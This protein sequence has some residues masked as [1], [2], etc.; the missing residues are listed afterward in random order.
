MARVIRRQKDELF[1]L[2]QRM[3][4]SFHRRITPIYPWVL[5]RVLP[6]EQQLGRIWVPESQNKVIYEGLVLETWQPFWRSF[7]KDAYDP[8]E[9]Q[10]ERFF[11]SDLKPGDHVLFPHFEGMPVPYLNEE[12]KDAYRLVRE[13]NSKDEKCEIYGK[14]EYQEPI[15]EQLREQFTEYFLM[16]PRSLGYTSISIDNFIS[17]LLKDFYVVRKTAEPRTTSGYNGPR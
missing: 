2:A 5:V 12:E 8:N 14:L 13:S 10:L 15:E 6:K 11:E 3:Y 4:K 16:K 7:S 9:E 17:G 1:D